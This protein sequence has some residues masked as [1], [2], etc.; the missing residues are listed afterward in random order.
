MCF[1]TFRSLYCDLPVKN[2]FCNLFD[3][4]KFCRS[5][6]ITYIEFTCLTGNASVP[7]V[8]VTGVHVYQI[9]TAS[10]ETGGTLTFVDI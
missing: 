10:M 9:T 5:Y 8:T 2:S 4:Y 6:F 7:W 1:Q 3:G